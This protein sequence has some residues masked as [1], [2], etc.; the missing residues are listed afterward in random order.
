VRASL[1]GATHFDSILAVY[2][3]GTTC[4]CS[5]IF[6]SPLTCGDD[7]CGPGGGPS[8]VV[9]SAAADRCYL[10]R[11]AGWNGSTGNGVLQIS[12][13]TFCESPGDCDGDFRVDTYDVAHFQNCYTG[14]NGGP[15]PPHCTCVD[16]DGNG[17]VDQN[18]WR[19][20]VQAITGP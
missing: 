11:V 14:A 4:N 20:F 7:T 19:L 2:G 1:C 12:Y 18:D 9:F 6:G 5:Q 13:D 3:G 15:I 17:D 8:Q 16:L 10:I